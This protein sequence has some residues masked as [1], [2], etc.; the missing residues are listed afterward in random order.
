MSPGVEQRMHTRVRVR[1]R[2]RT[3][4]EGA[5]PRRVEIRDVGLGG[6][7]VAAVVRPEEL[8][9][10]HT[11]LVAQDGGMHIQFPAPPGSSFADEDGTVTVS[12]RP[13][14]ITERGL[15]VAFTDDYQALVHAIMTAAVGAAE[16]DAAARPKAAPE[17]E[18]L[19]RTLQGTVNEWLPACLTS[20]VNEAEARLVARAS[21]SLSNAEQTPYFDAITELKA[22]VGTL[23]GSVGEVLEARLQNL[24]QP[25]QVKQSQSGFGGGLSLVEKDEFEIYLTVA[26]MASKAEHKFDQELFELGR[27]LSGVAGTTIDN[28]NNPL[29]PAGF[30]DPFHEHMNDAAM[31]PD[32][33][34]LVYTAFEESVIRELDGLYDR[35]TERLR[36]SGVQPATVSETSTAAKPAATDREAAARGAETQPPDATPPANGS[37]ADDEMLEIPGDAGRSPVAQPNASRGAEPAVQPTIPGM[38][39]ASDAGDAFGAFG[40]N[41]F[42]PPAPVSAGETPGG[43][44][45]FG[46]LSPLEQAAGGG[47]GPPANAVSD[48]AGDGAASADPFA[49]AAG[50]GNRAVAPGAPSAG[51]ASVGGP[52]GAAPAREAPAAQPAPPGLAPGLTA[53]GDAVPEN[54]GDAPDPAAALSVAAAAGGAL[55]GPTVDAGTFGDSLELAATDTADLSAEAGLTGNTTSLPPAAAAGAPGGSAAAAPGLAGLV[56]DAGAGHPGLALA[57]VTTPSAG[58]AG[59]PGPARSA[60]AGPGGVMLRHV[61]PG[62]APRV[63]T[64]QEDYAIPAAPAGSAFGAAHALLGLTR[65]LA[66]PSGMP[67][68]N[69]PG[70]MPGDG[71]TPSGTAIAPGAGALTTEALLEALSSLQHSVAAQG[72]TPGASPGA[73]FRS[74][75]RDAL[76]FTPGIGAPQHGA[77]GDAVELMTCLFDAMREDREIEPELQPRLDM[78]E[79]AFHKVAVLDPTLFDNPEHTARRVLNQMAALLPELDPETPDKDEFWVGM[80]GL[81]EPLGARF[82]RDMSLFDAVLAELDAMVAFQQE[83]FSA[84]RQNVVDS[85]EAQDRFIR[86][87]RSRAAQTSANQ[88]PSERGKSKEWTVWLNRAARLKPGEYVE[89]TG[90]SGQVSRAQIAWVNADRSTFVLVDRQGLKNQTF[91]QQE[92]AMQLRRGSAAIVAET[93]LP[94]VDRA[95]S[96]VLQEMHGTVERHATRDATTGLLN[97]RTFIARLRG[98]LEEANTDGRGVAIVYFEIEQYFEVREKYGDEAADILMRRVARRAAPVFPGGSDLASTAPG[99]M[100]GFA[101]DRSPEEAQTLADDVCQTVNRMKVRWGDVQVTVRVRAGALLVSSSHDPDEALD[102]AISLVEQSSAGAD[103]VQLLSRLTPVS[104]TGAAQD[105]SAL[106][107]TTLSQDRLQ[108]RCH[109][110]V[111]LISGRR[112]RAHY[113]VMLGIRDESGDLI[114]HQDFVRAAEQHDQLGALDRWVLR[115][116]MR[117]MAEHRRW[118]RHIGGFALKISGASFVDEHLV[119]YVLD[120]LNETGV[121]PGKLIF[122]VS[123]R[124]I[125]DDNAHALNFVR[126]LSEVGCQFALDDFGSAQSGYGYLKQLPV[127]FVRVDGTFIRAMTAADADMAVVKSVNEVAHFMGKKSIAE[128]VGSA[129]V[130]ACLKEI[131][132]DYVQGDAIEAPLFFEELTEEVLKSAM[133]LPSPATSV[134]AQRRQ[135]RTLDPSEQTLD[136]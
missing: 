31:P 106:V 3:T 56:P 134:S 124:L 82:E 34:G 125:A 7:Y 120:Q 86:E 60:V 107:T 38:G 99:A 18:Q 44:G 70:L 113:E 55:A 89:L 68:G 61:S 85:S 17:Q 79:P 51:A 127:T 62:F 25:I 39:G 136:F 20:F 57:G 75:L 121:P 53:G 13:A 63:L 77:L 102:A 45:A 103:T 80:D 43:F 66:V 126:T 132:A 78:L 93:E 14:R 133:E 67:G 48:P 73:S 131:G 110:V 64:P 129:E 49:P 42:T 46:E 32:A 83:R 15:G 47:A 35:L 135:G 41:P 5:M 116:L 97:R 92:L 88:E 123:E 12:G 74:G 101:V 19:V 65:S 115:N 114:E 130:L 21:Q 100:V 54:P 36:V 16:A 128:E 40:G 33:L 69:S 22:L 84:N 105:Y 24:G 37:I 87:R 95:L 119:E 112:T 104:D 11:G 9:E 1:I 52:A 90:S 26:D 4:G 2:A 29:A 122:E 59:I 30:A 76:G 23:G 6:L 96:R 111:P 50:D 8:E 91:S 108:L 10:P 109:R 94:L 118:L 72:A 98:A 81:L 117:W 71:A 27:Y 58:P 28:A